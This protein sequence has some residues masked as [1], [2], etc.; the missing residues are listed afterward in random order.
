[1][2][3][4]SIN[5]ALFCGGRGSASIVRELLRWPNIHLTLLVNAYDDGLSTGALRHL[6][7]GMLGPSDFRKNLSYLLD[8]YSAQQ[9]ALQR[10]I[11]YRLP[12]DIS[13]DHIDELKR[14]ALDGTALKLLPPLA[15][16]LAG[17]DKHVRKRIREMLASFFGYVEA[18][19]HI[20]EYA[21]CSFGN[22]VFA[23]AYL[24]SSNFNTAARELAKLLG[25]RADL[26]N[27]SRGECRSLLA[28]KDDGALLSCEA[29]IVGK[30][31]PIA[32]RET[33]FMEEPITAEQWAAVADHPLAEKEAWLRNR[34]SP[35]ALSDEA[36]EALAK[37]E[38]IIYGPGT[39]FS[40]LLPSYRIAASALQKSP[41]SLKLLVLNLDHDYDIQ[42]FGATDIVDRVLGY[43]GD[44]ENEHRVITH[45]LYNK[46][47][48]SRPDGIVLERGL[49]DEQGRYRGAEIVERSLEN[50]AKPSVHSGNSVVRA[51]LE[52]FGTPSSLR[53]GE[54][55][56]IYTDLVQRQIGLDGLLQE[57]L[58]IDWLSDFR[59][60][61]LL[62]NGVKPPAPKLP[63]HLAIEGTEYESG[64][65]ESTALVDWLWNRDSD[66]LATLTGDGE[67]HLR[68]VLLG[69]KLLKTGNFGAVYGSRNQSRQQ[70]QTSL[71]SAYGEGSVLFFMS[72]IGAFLLTALFGLRFRVIFSDPL[73][74]FRI[75]RR[76]RL[77]RTFRGAIAKRKLGSAASITKLLVRSGIEIAEMP[78]SYRT[79][80]G[81]VRSPWRLWRGV[82]NLVG[83]LR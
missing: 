53:G 79:Y 83:I 42:S 28:V 25:S 8:L 46:G 81:F 9:Y 60:V 3:G 48:A 30:Q 80:A 57:F 26:V 54:S 43:A 36:K 11:E 12:L 16:M 18:N 1:M 74:G 21:D 2:C 40:S 45:V 10:L 77:D 65:S 17:V 56:D 19:E 6:I 61:K 15:Q 75:Y 50:P 82:R 49:L 64:F 62:T 38:V 68:D 31:S 66:Y 51:M 39:Q 29:E 32:I 4:R 33:F 14:F 41:A 5:V 78:V 69:V 24:Q 72:W 63:T 52:L 35:V 47:N 23:G 20:F 27:V 67:Y 44:R 22:L 7:P 55:I 71:N 37:A 73:T 34:E 13:S 58:E 70:F 59:Q 76:S